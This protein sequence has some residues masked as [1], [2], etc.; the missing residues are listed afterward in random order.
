V[1]KSVGM[2]LYTE[3]DFVDFTFKITSHKFQIWSAAAIENN[4]LM[5]F[6]G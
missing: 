3:K 6:R 1:T 4:G 5:I 2:I